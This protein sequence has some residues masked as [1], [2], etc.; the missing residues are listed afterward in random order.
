MGAIRSRIVHS[1]A[2]CRSER[3]V[4]S[5]S[6]RRVKSSHC[7][8]WRSCEPQRQHSAFGRF[9]ASLKRSK[10]PPHSGQPTALPRWRT[11]STR[12]RSAGP[13]RRR[14]RRPS[15]PMLGRRAARVLAQL[16][17]LRG[18]EQHRQPRA[19]VARRVAL[20][21]Q[22]DRGPRLARVERRRELRRDLARDPADLRGA[23][24]V[25]RDRA[26]VVLVAGVAPQLERAAGTDVL[27]GERGRVVTPG[28]GDPGDAQSQRGEL[29]RVAAQVATRLAL[30][31]L[32][33]REPHDA[34][35][36]WIPVALL[37]DDVDDRGI[38]H[39][40]SVRMTTEWDIEQ[41]DTG[42]YL[43]RIDY[44]GDTAPSAATLAALHPAHLAAIPFENLDIVLGRGISVEFE[45]V[46]RKLVDA[47][48]GGYCYEHGLLFGAVLERLGFEVDRLLARVAGDG[49]RPRART[50]MALRVRTGGQ[51]WLAGGRVGARLLGPP[52]VPRGRDGGPPRPG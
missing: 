38:G 26:R 36:V 52:P 49:S 32:V 39:A 25:H 45:A 22:D 9:Q 4:R 23:R 14:S 13:M 50:H 31:D 42:A 28:A 27:R 29:G 24:G 2:K 12:R 33:A 35:V 41:L 48:R 51:A 6:G 3:G 18:G 5:R 20:L 16:D 19:R 15:A 21:A 10:R 46:Q 30:D 43:R 8:R 17:R 7:A 34:P 44:D 1:G 47:R 40:V 37:E 11:R